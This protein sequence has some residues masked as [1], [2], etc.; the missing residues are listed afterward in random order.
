MQDLPSKPCATCGRAFT[1][2]RAYAKVWDEVRHCSD[3]CR[4]HRPGRRDRA[5]EAAI[6]AL[7]AARAPGA[8]VCPSEAARVVAGDNEALWRPLMKPAR[9]AAR[10]LVAAGLIEV[11]QRGRVVDPAVAR[12]PIRLRVVAP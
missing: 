10:R 1:W 2:R 3:A 12:G 7:L 9:R 8:T 4:R 5:L 11:V 6:L